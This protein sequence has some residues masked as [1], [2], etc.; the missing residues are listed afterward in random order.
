MEDMTIKQISRLIEW[1]KA[2][3]FTETDIIDCIEYLGK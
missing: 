3:G 2:K 1:L